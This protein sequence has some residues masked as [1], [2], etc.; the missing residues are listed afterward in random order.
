M[1]WLSKHGESSTK[2]SHFS[3]LPPPRS[4]TSGRSTL[5]RVWTFHPSSARKV[6][7]EST[8]GRGLPSA[9]GPLVAGE[10]AA[11]YLV[12]G[13]TWKRKAPPSI[14]TSTQTLVYWKWG[15]Y[16][17]YAYNSYN[18]LFDKWN[19]HRNYSSA[20]LLICTC[21]ATSNIF[22]RNWLEIRKK[23]LNLGELYR[24]IIRYRLW[25]HHAI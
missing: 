11:S 21:S 7:D 5:C 24:N 19:S 2:N 12:A 22:K 1:S 8:I 4:S 25:M 20:I 17:T 3:P 15:C 13:E 14:T 10:D 6:K 23:F 18:L 9:H 16:Q